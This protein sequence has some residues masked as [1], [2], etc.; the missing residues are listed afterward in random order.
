MSLNKISLALIPRSKRSVIRW[1]VKHSKLCNLGS[2]KDYSLIH[3]KRMA[4]V[5]NYKGIECRESVYV[6]LHNKIKNKCPR[7]CKLIMR[8]IESLQSERKF[9]TPKFNE[10]YLDKVLPNI[11]PVEKEM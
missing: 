11:K 8:N 6:A 10:L 1:I 9:I 7:L 2:V 4:Y 5:R 3:L